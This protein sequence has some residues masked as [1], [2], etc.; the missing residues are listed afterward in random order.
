MCSYKIS[1]P[2]TGRSEVSAEGARDPPF[3]GW[4][5][6]HPRGHPHLPP[7]PGNECLGKQS[8][9]FPLAN[10]GSH[11]PSC[12][13]QVAKT[14]ARA[15][16]CLR[17]QGRVLSWAVPPSWLALT[18]P[19]LPVRSHD[20]F[21]PSLADCISHVCPSHYPGAVTPGSARWQLCPTTASLPPMGQNRAPG[22]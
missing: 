15:F 22:C 14:T 17:A 18:E 5:G 13:G 19:P 21:G 1:F 20:T 6:H 8:A 11:T 4:G 7:A 9:L 12:K 2:A 16:G 3:P 10:Y